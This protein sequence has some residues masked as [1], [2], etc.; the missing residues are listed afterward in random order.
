MTFKERAEKCTNPLSKHLFEVGTSAS[1]CERERAHICY[2]CVADGKEK[3]QFMCGSGHNRKR[4]TAR[5]GQS[6][7]GNMY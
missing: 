3:E 2:C 5:V 1:V 7:N 4:K 6:G